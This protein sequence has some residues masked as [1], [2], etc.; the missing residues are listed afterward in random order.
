M[1]DVGGVDGATLAPPA[2]VWQPPTLAGRRRGKARLAAE[3]ALRASAADETKMIVSKGGRVMPQ[4][5]IGLWLVP[6]LSI[7]R[8]MA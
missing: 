5:S 7:V 2:C 4:I 3:G 1:D 6:S 8:L